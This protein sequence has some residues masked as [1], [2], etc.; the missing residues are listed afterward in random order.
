MCTLDRRPTCNREPRKELVIV[1]GR[2]IIVP[3]DPFCEL[4]ARPSVLGVR[5]LNGSDPVAVGVTAEG[6]SIGI[7]PLHSHRRTEAR[8]R[9]VFVY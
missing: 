2:V 1:R 5:N 3:L 8:C 9:L 6:D 4:L 7:K